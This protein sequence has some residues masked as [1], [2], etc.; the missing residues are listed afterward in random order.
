VAR[1]EKACEPTASPESDFGELQ[2][3]Q[4][5]LSSLHSKL[6]PASVALK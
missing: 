2:P 3:A 1:T 4:L 5:A 6:E